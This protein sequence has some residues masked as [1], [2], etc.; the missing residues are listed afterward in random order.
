MTAEGDAAAAGGP[1]TGAAGGTTVA[2]GDTTGAD[3]GLTGA[4]RDTTG[5]GGFVG[6]FV[7]AIDDA[8]LPV[9]RI[10][11][12]A[13]ASFRKGLRGKARRQRFQ[14]SLRRIAIDRLAEPREGVGRQHPW[15]ERGN[16]R[17]YRSPRTTAPCLR[18][19]R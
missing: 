16:R 13:D 1:G 14:D 17:R 19:I 7:F 11:T 4:G 12:R 3:G 8:G 10:F 6:V 18:T 2:A 5:A 9:S 15:R